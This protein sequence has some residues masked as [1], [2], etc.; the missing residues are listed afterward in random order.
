[1]IATILALVDAGG[2]VGRVEGSIRIHGEDSQSIADW[3]ETET[4]G[5][6]Q[7]RQDTKN[8]FVSFVSLWSVRHDRR[9]AGATACPRSP[10]GPA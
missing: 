3:K 8:T 4:A 5:T 2:F 6:P 9:L 1:M 7:R 10:E